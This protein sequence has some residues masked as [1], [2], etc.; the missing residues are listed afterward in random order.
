MP[1]HQVPHAQICC[2]ICIYQRV[3]ST[4]LGSLD[5]PVILRYRQQ[6]HRSLD[7][8]FNSIIE[9]VSGGFDKAKN[10]LVVSGLWIASHKLCFRPCSRFV[11]NYPYWENGSL[12]DAATIARGEM[13]TTSHATQRVYHKA[14]P[15]ILLVFRRS[16]K[17]ADAAQAAYCL[18]SSVCRCRYYQVYFQSARYRTTTSHST[19][20]AF[21]YENLNQNELVL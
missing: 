15:V 14:H 12:L 13:K 1:K 20:S 4:D 9:E 16:T 19:R 5:C 10:A 2:Y 8:A 17:Q 3:A 7:T 6:R 11:S 21:D 18:Q